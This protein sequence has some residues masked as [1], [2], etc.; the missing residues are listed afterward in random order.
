MPSRKTLCVYV[1]TE[2]K[3]NFSR[4]PF[5]KFGYLR[6][7]NTLKNKIKNLNKKSIWVI[8]DRLEIVEKA[9]KVNCKIILLANGRERVWNI[10]NLSYPDFISFSPKEIEN[11]LNLL[12]YI[13]D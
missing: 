2:Q 9:R 10:S 12:R 6:S 1:I 13:S 3:I 7:S 11:F 5:V 8:T 4:I